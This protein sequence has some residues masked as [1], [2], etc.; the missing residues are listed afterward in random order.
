MCGIYCMIAC[1]FGAV[2][3]ISDALAQTESGRHLYYTEV[4]LF[5]DPWSSGRSANDHLY[6]QK[7]IICIS[8]PVLLMRNSLN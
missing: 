8:E 4:S 5:G 3:P 7:Q 6:L 2:F 1:V